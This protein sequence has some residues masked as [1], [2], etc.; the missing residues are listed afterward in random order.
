MYTEYS[1]LSGTLCGV[2]ASNFGSFHSFCDSGGYSSYLEMLGTPLSSYCF[3]RG[4]LFFVDSKQERCAGVLHSA[5]NCPF[6]FILALFLLSSTENMAIVFCCANSNLY[7][8]Q[9]VCRF[10]PMGRLMTDSL[11]DD[12]K[13]ATKCDVNLHDLI[14]FSQQL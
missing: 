13:P 1:V 10:S 11:D 5:W 2:G 7:F 8:W 6:I 3:R 12:P 4:F 14:K 9:V